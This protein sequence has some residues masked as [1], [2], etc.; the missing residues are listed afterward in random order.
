M[1]TMHLQKHRICHF[2]DSHAYNMVEN[3]HSSWLLCLVDLMV[4][5]AQYEVKCKVFVNRAAKVG[6]ENCSL[7]WS[8][9]FL[10]PGPE[11][12]GGY[13]RLVPHFSE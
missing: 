6:R 1:R 7:Q 13:Y 12:N 8:L 4:G 9:F 11:S 2:V 10:T 3:T 5:S